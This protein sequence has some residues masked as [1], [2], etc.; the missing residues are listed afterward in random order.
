SFTGAPVPFG[1]MKASGLGREGGSEG[2]EPFTE[3]K[4][5]CLGD[6]GLPVTPMA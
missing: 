4:Y 1:G 5:F 2:F 3:T 6:L